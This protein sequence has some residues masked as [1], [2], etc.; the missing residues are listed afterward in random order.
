MPPKKKTTRKQGKEPVVPP[1]TDGG[2]GAKLIVESDDILADDVP[3]PVTEDASSSSMLGPAASGPGPGASTDGSKKGAGDDSSDE[4]GGFNEKA[5]AGQYQKLGEHSLP[6]FVKIT[7]KMRKEYFR[8]DE[9]DYE[10]RGLKCRLWTERAIKGLHTSRRQNS[11]MECKQLQHQLS[12]RRRHLTRKAATSK[13]ELQ[14]I[15]RI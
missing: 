8:V 11:R 3:P 9:P 6:S 10:L 14:L 7:E 2:S 12:N 5:V 4:E 13:V 1:T 15:Y